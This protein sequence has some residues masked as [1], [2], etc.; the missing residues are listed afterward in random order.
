M[1]KHNR[2]PNW[3][4]WQVELA[5]DPLHLEITLDEVIADLTYP[6]S[7]ENDR[8]RERRPQIPAAA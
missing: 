8:A 3:T 5:T 4:V 6:E 2:E 1:S 7:D